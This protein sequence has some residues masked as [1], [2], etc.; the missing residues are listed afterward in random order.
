M[1]RRCVTIATVVVAGI[2]LVGCSAGSNGPD[3]DAGS[4]NDEAS[5]P[6]AEYLGQSPFAG[7]FGQQVGDDWEPSEQDRLNHR[8]YEEAVADCMQEAGFEYVPRTMDLSGTPATYDEAYS[9]EP[10]E[11]AAQYGYGITTLMFTAENNQ[12]TDPNEQIRSALSPSA[13]QAYEATLWGEGDVDGDPAAAPSCSN[14]AY[15]EAYDDG[16]IGVTVD[17]IMTE[18]SALFDDLDALHERVSRDPRVV[19]AVESWRRCM[20]D[21]GYPELD[22]P[23]DAAADIVVRAYDAMVPADEGEVAGDAG[24]VVEGDAR[25][26]IDPR[27]FAELQREEIA[28]AGVDYACREA[29]YTA[30]LVEVAGQLEREF[31]QAHRNDLERYRDWRSAGG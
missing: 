22:H 2:A 26:V 5:S 29:H 16:D 14:R 6:L 21:G 24:V 28:L 11:F 3:D 31:V 19:D 7:G 12:V 13:R 1:T 15:A 10:A 25:F 27:E 23:D 4:A 20:A 8:R 18:L 30:T 17:Q 9:L